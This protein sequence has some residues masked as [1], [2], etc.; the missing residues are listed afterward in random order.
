MSG[1][2]AM[3]KF[4]AI[5]LLTWC[6]TTSVVFAYGYPRFW[7]G[8][9]NYPLVW[10][11]RGEAVY[12][13]KSSIKI[14]LNDSPYYIITVQTISVYPSDYSPGNELY[15]NDKEAGST[16][17]Y[18]FFYDEEEMDMRE[19]HSAVSNGNWMYLRPQ[20]GDAMRGRRIYIGEAIFY[21][22]TGRKFYGNY[23]W[24]AIGTG[25]GLEAY[26]DEQGNDKYWD[27]FS[28]ATYKD[29]R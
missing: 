8:D 24:K 20:D 4:W 28:D 17:D 1:A 27:M 26:K 15:S 12:L 16:M 13:D 3:K 5:F 19:K 18:E 2:I 6:F 29:L 22:A 14:N 9:T 11:R 21:V 7:K 10:G 23:L 25:A